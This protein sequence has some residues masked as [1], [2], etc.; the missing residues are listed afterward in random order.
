MDKLENPGD[1]A[2]RTKMLGFR[3]MA[4]LE[5]KYAEKKHSKESEH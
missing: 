3:G 4:V 1:P 2:R 5:F